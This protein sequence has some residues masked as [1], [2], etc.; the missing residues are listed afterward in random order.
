MKDADKA[1]IQNGIDFK[2]PDSATKESASKMSLPKVLSD[3]KLFAV[4]PQAIESPGALSDYLYV[5]QASL[6]ELLDSTFFELTDELGSV[7]EHL[8]VWEIRLLLLLF[9]DQLQAAKREATL[10]NNA[11]YIHENPGAPATL[12]VQNRPPNG[13]NSGSSLASIPPGPVY[14]L[15]NNNDEKIPDSLLMLLLSLKAAPNLARVNEIYRLCYQKRLKGES[16]EQLVFLSTKNGLQ[17]KLMALA[18]GVVAV[19]FVSRNHATVVTFLGSMRDDLGSAIR[20]AKLEQSAFK[21]AN[22]EQSANSSQDTVSGIECY[23]S[24]VTLM[25]VLAKIHVRR[26]SSSSSLEA[27]TWGELYDHE[28]ASIGEGT[29][30]SLRFVTSKIAPRISGSIQKLDLAN[31]S[32]KKLADLVAEDKLSVRTICCLLAL[33]SVAATHTTTLTEDTFTVTT[34]EGRTNL[35]KTYNFVTNKWGEY[36]NKLYGL[37]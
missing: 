37:E 26:G 2:A 12:N 15:P 8:A 19:L 6:T 32:T 30:K 29:W 24:N 23:Y 17:A 10:L 20:S 13:P 9:T 4:V 3:R 14:P 7:E 33:W 5:S 31:L 27:E 34:E 1:R 16:H 11:L 18:Y 35:A 28:L 21:S 25:W 36:F 22:L